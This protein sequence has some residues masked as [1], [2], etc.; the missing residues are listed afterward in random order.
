MVL[1]ALKLNMKL[2]A[3]ALAATLALA[4]PSFAATPL[5]PPPTVAAKGY[6][7]VDAFSGRILAGQ[8]DT[9]RLEPASLTKLMT[10]YVVFH[11]LKDGKLRLDQEVPISE[12]AWKAEGSRTF[13]NVGTRVRVDTLIQ[14]MIIQSGN[15]AT[16]ALAEAVAGSEP[17]FASLM[18]QYAQR[19][20]L[21]RKSTR[22]NSSH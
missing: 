6:V 22:L 4:S 13:L 7:V 14:G 5:P 2:F 17:T 12:H 3:L 19:V 21:D 10:A 1:V 16:I 8:N 18:N 15:D 20:G 11:A 9:E